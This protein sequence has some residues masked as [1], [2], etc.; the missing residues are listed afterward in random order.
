MLCEHDRLEVFLS[1]LLSMDDGFLS[2]EWELGDIGRSIC[3]GDYV[4][5]CVGC[6][7]SCL[8]VD[9]VW[10]VMGG[11]GYMVRFG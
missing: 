1:F 8:V 11:M 10:S 7:G 3:R 9:G 2:C 6:C 5:G 4:G